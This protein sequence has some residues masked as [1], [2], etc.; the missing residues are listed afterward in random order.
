[1]GY[2]HNKE[3]RRLFF[4]LVVTFF[5][6][7]II[8]ISGCGNLSQNSDELNDS[9][10]FNLPTATP[11]GT[12]EFTIEYDTERSNYFRIEAYPFESNMQSDTM[13]VNDADR[14]G[15]LDNTGRKKVRIR[16]D[17]NVKYLIK[18]YETQSQF[19]QDEPIDNIEYI[20]T[21]VK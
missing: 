13:F 12:R 21:V 19:K 9:Y 6:V 7:C 1:M 8:V 3:R 4:Q 18:F 14:Q 16:I 17:Y 15:Q 20:N 11:F 5:L 10:A 2:K